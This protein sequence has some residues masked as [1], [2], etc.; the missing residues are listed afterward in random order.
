MTRT[1]RVAGTVLGRCTDGHR[2]LGHAC[3]LELDF[4][5]LAFPA[6]AVYTFVG[7]AIRSV[8]SH[9]VPPGLRSSGEGGWI[10]V[11]RHISHP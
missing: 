11:S 1:S 6:V 2:G 5:L 8:V 7:F 10:L 3:Q 4:V 9:R